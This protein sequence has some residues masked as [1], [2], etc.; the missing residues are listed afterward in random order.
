MSTICQLWVSGGKG[1]MLKASNATQS[2]KTIFISYILKYKK[3]LLDGYKAPLMAPPYPKVGDW[4]RAALGPR[5]SEYE[6]A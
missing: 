5:L 4:Y 2:N 6:P 1:L 3:I